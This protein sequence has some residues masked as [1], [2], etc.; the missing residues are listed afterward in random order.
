MIRNF[1]TIGY[2]NFRKGRIYSFT[3]LFGLVVGLSSVML[4]I[5]YIRYELSFDK[6]FSN[7]DRIY[8]LVMESNSTDP[9]ERTVQT[10]EALGKTL[11]A[12][13]FEIET[14]TSLLPYKTTYLVDDRPVQ[15][16]SIMVNP[17][18]LEIFDLPITQGDKATALKDKSGIVLS[19]ETAEKLFPGTDAVGKTLTRKSFNGALTYYTVTA[20]AENIPANTHFSA[21]VILSQPVSTQTL[22]F[23]GYSGLPQY[24]LFKPKAN[25]ARVEARMQNVLTK[26]NLNK[27]TSIRLLPLI[28][29]HLR[30]GKISSANLNLSDIRYIYIF[31]IAAVLILLIGCINYMNLTTAQALQRVKEVGIRKTL[32]SG[33]AQLA[34][35]FIGESFL[36]FVLATGLG[37]IVS[38]LALPVFNKL[39]QVNLL[40]SDLL[41]LRNLVLF[42]LISLGAGALSG[43]YPALFLS[44]LQPASILKDRS[45]GLNINFSL[46]K[47][48]IVLQF[49]ISLVLIVA[50]IVVW[51]QLHLFNS[52]PLG[53][54]KDHLLILPSIHLSSKPEAF[55]SKL[56]SSPNIGSVSFA[57]LNL[58]NSIGNTSSMTDPADSSH[59]L[60]FG[61]VYGDQD[62]LKTM[63]IKVKSG[64]DFSHESP[65]DYMDYDSLYT[66]ARKE[67]D[68]KLADELLYQSPIIITESLAKALRLK[69]PVNEVIKLGALQGT[70]IGVVNDFQV[71]TLKETSPLLVYKPK[72]GWFGTTTYI[73]LNNRNIPESIRYI[74]QTWKEFFP[75]ENFHYSFADDNLQKLY[76]SENR[77]ASIFTSFALLAISISALGLF[78]LAALVVKQRT[79]EISIRKVLGASVSGIALLLSRDFIILILIAVV[80]ASPVAWY[81]MNRWLQDFA[82]RIDIQWWT[83]VLAAALALFTGVLTV[84]LQTIKAAKANPTESLKRE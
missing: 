69:Q 62:F 40:V 27:T 18:F 42:L 39:L 66:A 55:K 46:R 16:N 71:T 56:L 83:F 64:R 68:T 3:N 67:S 73:R 35:Q 70:V 19:R 76:E 74:E 34:F 36:F 75:T 25:I 11:A 17:N 84:S 32:G 45:G 30:T 48:L 33:R 14:F 47:I 49:S 7:S 51:Q 22:N 8:Y 4:I 10:P 60:H 65:S 77:L 52:R 50:T 2:R 13:F 59:S 5:A 58:G 53:F 44:K 72:K 28:D 26:Y 57:E 24:I 78:S 9:I 61:F 63:D 37:A 54:N 12:E 82:N 1:L 15:L 29:I 81:G 38:V 21:D 31:G 79:K 6:H 80:I 20:I 43:I 41:C 23:R